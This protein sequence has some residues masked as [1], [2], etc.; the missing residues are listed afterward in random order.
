MFRIRRSMSLIEFTKAFIHAY[1]QHSY[2]I[3]LNMLSTLC[4]INNMQTQQS[5]NVQFFFF[6]VIILSSVQS[7]VC[8]LCSI[9]IYLF[10]FDWIW[11]CICCWLFSF[12]VA[13]SDLLC[14]WFV[15]VFH[16]YWPLYICT[17]NTVN[18]LTKP[19]VGVSTCLQD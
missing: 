2:N 17:N 13:I 16:S 4:S 18:E 12:A 14:F 3:I 10:C 1:E 6:L 9:T 7:A 11:L 15:H 5:E 19:L 8:M